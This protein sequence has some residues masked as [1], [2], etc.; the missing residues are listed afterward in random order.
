M[1]K[2]IFIYTLFLALTFLVGCTSNKS[3]ST[4]FGGKIINPKSKFVTLHSMEKV[5]DTLF[6]DE[7]NRFI[8]K[9]EN[10][11]EGLYY[12]IHGN[13]NQNIY[14]E[15]LDSLML[16][17]NTW[18][19]DESLVFAGK[20]A[21]RNNVLIDCFLADEKDD[22]IT[23]KFNKLA[24]KEFKEKTD[25][26]IKLKLAT[27]NK[28][29]ENHPEETVG[30]KHLLKVALTYP[31]YS[32]IERYP[33]VHAKYSKTK[34]FPETDVNFYNYRKEITINKDSL[35]YYVPYSKY[36]KNFLYNITYS[37]GYKPMTNEYSSNFTNDLLNTID[38]KVCSSESKN[39]FLK[40]TVIG[41][42]YK[43]STCNVNEKAF[44][45]FFELSTNEKD[46]KQIKLLLNDSKFLQKN[47]K[48]PDF[49]LTDFTNGNHSINKIT[50]NNKTC[51]LF[52][53]QE[54]F[55]KNYISSRI[56]YLSKEFPEIQFL[57]VKFDCDSSDRIPNLDIK[58]QF[59]IDNKSEANNFLTSKMPRAI[60]ISKKGIIVNSFASISSNNIVF[61]LK[62][63][64]EK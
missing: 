41:H 56:N 14:L 12:F 4:Y 46:L 20:G 31:I 38:A 63:L 16:R 29:V 9:L 2:K 50:K 48:M 39:A 30:F 19:F 51:L 33:I 15:P 44:N 49:I 3:T 1:V 60:L 28:Y 13:E 42:F 53:N 57:Q 52:W 7:E 37:L 43:R 40:Q 22:K 24:P 54:Y 26:L 17:L 5:V 36:V 25:S 10:F 11:D 27:Y 35:M 55:S 23:Y 47:V 8:G 61:Q 58:N 6:L 32:K 34:E 59:F 45:T 64:S 18:D 21:E 62:E